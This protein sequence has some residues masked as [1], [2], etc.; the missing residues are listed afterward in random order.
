MTKARENLAERVV[1]RGA[2]LVSLLRE[3]LV[4]DAIDFDESANDR[5]VVTEPP[6]VV[7]VRA[8]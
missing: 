7:T 4:T 3:D 8:P 6:V 1:D 5:G 2:S